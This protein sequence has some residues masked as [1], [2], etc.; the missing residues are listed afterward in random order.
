MRLFAGSFGDEGLQTDQYV[1]W[2]RDYCQAFFCGLSVKL[3]PA[4][5]VSET[6]CSFRVNSSSHN[7]QILTGNSDIFLYPSFA[8]RCQCFPFRHDLFVV[9]LWNKGDL[10]RYLGKRKPKDAFCIVGI[11]MI[12]LYPKDS[13]N[14]VFGQASL[15][16]GELF[17]VIK[18]NVQQPLDGA[19]MYRVWL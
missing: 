6:G 11:T 16:D 14:F 13:W 7:L 9:S 19:Q 4:V 5:S 2:L 8:S 12:D 15:S 17:V 1:E 3:L 18:E 10:L